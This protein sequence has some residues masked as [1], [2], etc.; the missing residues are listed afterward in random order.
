MQTPAFFVQNGC[1]HA[2]RM[3]G[4]HEAEAAQAQ[5]P[6]PFQSGLAAYHLPEGSIAAI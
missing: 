3:M 6:D 2:K 1:P 5:Q 4:G